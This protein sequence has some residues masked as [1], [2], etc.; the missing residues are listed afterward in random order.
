MLVMFLIYAL[1]PVLIVLNIANTD[2]NKIKRC[3]LLYGVP[4]IILTMINI[5]VFIY[6]QF[7]KKV[8]FFDENSFTFLL[9]GLSLM[10]VLI[11]YNSGRRQEKI[12][13]TEI[14]SNEI[15]RLRNNSV[16]SKRH[17]VVL[18]NEEIIE[19]L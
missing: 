6:D 16:S 18:S 10:L 13:Q 9:P 14:A 15:E 12:I 5:F 17:D 8:K 3:R 11:V 4:A 2:N 1:I 7:Y 19:K